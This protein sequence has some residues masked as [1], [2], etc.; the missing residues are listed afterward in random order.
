MSL[1]R[2]AEPLFFLDYLS[3]GKIELE[4][5]VKIVEELLRDV[6]RPVALFWVVKPLKCP[7]F[8]NW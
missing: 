5:S 1:F 4:K 2:G 6:S 8:I 3:T 7:V